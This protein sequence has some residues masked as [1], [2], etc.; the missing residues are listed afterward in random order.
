MHGQQNIKFCYFFI[1]TCTCTSCCQ[2]WS[3]VDSILF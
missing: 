3:S 2:W 1:C